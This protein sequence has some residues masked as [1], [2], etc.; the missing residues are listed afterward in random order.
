MDGV[1]KVAV[2][3]GIQECLLGFGL[4]N[5]DGQDFEVVHIEVLLAASKNRRV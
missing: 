2:G 4:R 3:R 1:A 5:V